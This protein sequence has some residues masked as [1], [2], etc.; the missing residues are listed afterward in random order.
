VTTSKRTVAA[1]LAAATA[2][3]APVALAAPADTGRGPSTITDPYLVP[4]ADGVSLRSLLTVDDAGSASDGYEMAGIPDGLGAFV[5]RL[6]IDARTLEVTEGRELIDPG[7]QDWD[8]A[9]GEYA[10]AP[11]AGDTAAFNRLCGGT[12]WQDAGPPIWF[13]N[14]ENGDGGRNFGVTA[15]GTAK[16]LPRLGRHSY[17]NT[18]PALDTGRRTV[19]V[20][21]EDTAAG[22]LWVY[23][24]T[25]RRAGD[26]FD[27]AGLTNGVLSVLRVA[28]KRGGT[29]VSTD[30]GFRAA[31]GKGT[32]APVDLAN[33]DWDQPAAAQNTQGAAKGLSLNRIEDAS[34]DPRRPDDLYFVTT[35]GSPDPSRNRDG[36]GLWRL[37][38]D[39]REHPELG[40]TLTLLLDGTEAPY[41]NK[42]DNI[43]V[44]R[45]GN[46][47]VQ[48]DPG[49]NPHL[50]RVVAYRIADGERAVLAQFDPALFAPATPGG[51]DAAL[52]TDEE[53]SGII[54]AAETLGR[55]WY[56]LDAQVHRSS[57][58]PASVE[59]GQL[60]A[61]HV[62]DWRDVY[63]G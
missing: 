20:S 52:T 36:G 26:A 34:W 54:D 57:P 63:G 21:T 58:N 3:T 15:G 51:T 1:A 30:A 9:A 23:A 47:L 19:A 46:L 27:R 31:Y 55:G 39:D 37:R 17:E 48:E 25:K 24:G 4:V 41:L 35:E 45:R 22:Q 14:E 29:R 40:G 11:A 60:L 16:E 56:L 12:L 10:S 32:P 38:L 59:L 43:E 33:V 7:V 62:R 13:A 5:S 53:S 49:R 42:P 6:R 8:P 50:A 28:E 18:Q 44:D 2:L 61:L